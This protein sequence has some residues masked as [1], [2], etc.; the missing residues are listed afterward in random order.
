VRRRPAAPHPLV[1]STHRLIHDAAD[2][3]HPAGPRPPGR[4]R[5]R[6]DAV[7]AD[8]DWLR[9]RWQIRGDIHEVFL[10]PSDEPRIVRGSQPSAR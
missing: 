6:P 1:G 2:R 8:R 5:Q 10:A 4:P 3:G 9:I 7:Y